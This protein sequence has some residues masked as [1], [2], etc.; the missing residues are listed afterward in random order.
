MHLDMDNKLSYLSGES[1][2]K[3][4][5]S[6]PKSQSSDSKNQH[7]D[8]LNGDDDK[9]HST[10]EVVDEKVHSNVDGDKRKSEVYTE[11]IVYV[12]EENVIPKRKLSVIPQKDEDLTV[13]GLIRH[14]SV[15]PPRNPPS[16]YIYIHGLRRPFTFAQFYAVLDKFGTFD[17]EDDT[18]TDN[19]RSQSIIKYATVEEAQ[20]ARDGLHHVV[21][22]DKN[23]SE[24]LVDFTDEEEFI[25][26]KGIIK[27]VIKPEN[28][29]FAKEKSPSPM[30]DDLPSP[31]EV[32]V[33]RERLDTAEDNDEGPS[34][35]KKKDAKSLEELFKRTTA[36]PSLYYLPLSD[37]EVA[38]KQVQK[39]IEKRGIKE[40]SVEPLPLPLPVEATTSSSSKRREK[41]PS[42]LPIRRRS[43]SPL[44]RNDKVSPRPRRS[45][46]RKSSPPRRNRDGPP[47]PRRQRS[48][49]RSRSPPS[50]RRS[51]SPR[52]SPPS[53][54]KPAAT[55]SASS[56][57]LKKTTTSPPP[58]RRRS[59]SPR[60][61]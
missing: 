55:T 13:D 24:L 22:P 38:R 14:K 40:A 41:S 39:A 18:W 30:Q 57:S 25:Q 56:P 43:R 61:R 29:V 6:T 15:S 28:D 46:P 8:N 11:G 21:W 9:Q 45:P 32:A 16:N 35:K 12:K 2:N 5:S 3:S 50:K 49:R 10:N 20:K 36:Q 26:Q 17:K 53:S 47:P 54:R 7:Q 42:P 52:R 4:R 60:R 23:N 1:D 51:P 58:Q 27:K 31:K 37:E 48:P 59:P 44:R 33:K 19:L 34:R